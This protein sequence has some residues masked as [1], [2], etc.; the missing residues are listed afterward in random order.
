MHYMMLLAYVRSK[1]F[2]QVDEWLYYRGINAWYLVAH[3]TLTT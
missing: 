1:Q 3:I 2:K